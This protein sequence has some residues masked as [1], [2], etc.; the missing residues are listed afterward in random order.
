MAL[1]PEVAARSEPELQPLLRQRG[2]AAAF[3]DKY[4]AEAERLYP[5]QAIREQ[6]TFFAPLVAAGLLAAGDRNGARQLLATAIERSRDVRD[7]ELAAEWRAHLESVVRRLDGDRTVDLTA[8]MA[9]HR[10]EPL[11]PHLR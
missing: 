1:L 4:L 5:R 8:V 9:D 2:G 7:Q 6:R 3:A 11:L 10:M